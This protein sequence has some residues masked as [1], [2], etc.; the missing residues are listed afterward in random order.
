MAI[1]RTAWS[2]RPPTSSRASWHSHIR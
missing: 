2:I 1:S